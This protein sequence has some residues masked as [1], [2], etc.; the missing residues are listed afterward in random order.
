MAAFTIDIADND[1]P[2]VITA[3]C[4]NYGYQADIPNPDFNPEEDI[5]PI[6][7][8]ET[9]P[10]PETTN[11]FANRMTRDFLMQNTVAYEI[12]VE[13]ANITPPTPPVIVDPAE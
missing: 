9:I 11:Q 3:M 12:K 1:V 4:A 10:N 2:R 7:N 13:K 5:D 6:T 8:P